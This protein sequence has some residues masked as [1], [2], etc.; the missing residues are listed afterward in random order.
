MGRGRNVDG[1]SGWLPKLWKRAESM[2]DKPREH[3]SVNPSIR[4]PLPLPF[5]TASDLGRPRLILPRL[6]FLLYS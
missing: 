3:H 5:L 4:S 6:P 1:G 2:Q